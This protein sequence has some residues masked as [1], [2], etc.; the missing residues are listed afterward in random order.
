[1]YTSDGYQ[2]TAPVLA[3]HNEIAIL[4]VGEMPSP[5]FQVSS[6]ELEGY[7]IEM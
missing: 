5:E 3:V 1:V 6:V 7:A 4:P 2:P